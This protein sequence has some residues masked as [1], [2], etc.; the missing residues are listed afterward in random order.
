MFRFIYDYIDFRRKTVPSYS[1]CGEDRII[2]NL[3][4]MCG[5]I[6]PTYIDIG[7]YH[8]FIL[9]NTALLY[10]N[11]SR[12]INIEPDPIQFKII[13]RHRKNDINLNIG[14]APKKGEMDFYV[15]NARTLSTFSKTEAEKYHEQGKYFVK[16]TI[17][18]KTDTLINII[19]K[20]ANGIF[21]DFLSLDAEGTDKD[22]ISSIDFKNNAPK[23]IC[24][25][26]LSFNKPIKRNTELISLIINSGYNHYV[27]TTINSI[28][29]KKSIW[30]QK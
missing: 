22:I 13:N 11:G 25:E 10:R 17:R 28:F 20:H 18:V 27:D 3:F 29:V 2:E 16:K 8:P 5:I 7:A 23:I 24:V 26:T 14:I 9:S 21:P 6:Q 19:E 4:S 12:G 1:Q 30:D 15:L